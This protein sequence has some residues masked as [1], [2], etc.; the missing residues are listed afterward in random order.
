M[1]IVIFVDSLVLIFNSVF[2]HGN[3]EGFTGCSLSTTASFSSATHIIPARIG[4]NSCMKKRNEWYRVSIQK[5]HW[6]IHTEFNQFFFLSFTQKQLYEFDY[7][8]KQN[9][10]KLNGSGG[11]SSEIIKFFKKLNHNSNDDHCTIATITR[12]LLLSNKYR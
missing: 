4:W 11:I 8:T 6:K 9:K 7:K 3:L 5:F 12:S 1:Q 10:T 2:G